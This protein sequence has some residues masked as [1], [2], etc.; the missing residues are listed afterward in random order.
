MRKI[1]LI[2]YLFKYLKFIEIKNC[3]FDIDYLLPFV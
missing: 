2:L 3:Y 1:K